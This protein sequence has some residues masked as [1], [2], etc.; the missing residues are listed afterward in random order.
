MKT[1]DAGQLI[2][3]DGHKVTYEVKNGWDPETCAQCDALWGAYSVELLGHIA[4]LGL[5]GDK[6]TEVI[7][8][9]QLEDHGWSWAKKAELMIEDGFEWFYL[10]AEGKPQGACVIYHPKESVLRKANIFYVEFLVA[11]PWNR[12]CSIRKREIRGVGTALLR[13]AQRYSVDQLKL[14]VGFSLLSLPQ[15]VGYY[16]KL[17]MIY[18]KEHDHKRLSYFEL[19][20]DVATELMGVA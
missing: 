5:T 17:K 7:G 18:I 10:F 16:R 12:D 4:H 13:A 6:L 19:P 2:H 8:S 9:M 3:R 14:S 20:E 11:A 1:I 15:A